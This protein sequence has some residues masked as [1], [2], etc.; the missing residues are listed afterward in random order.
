MKKFFCIILSILM[1]SMQCSCNKNMLNQSE[2]LK[3]FDINKAIRVVN[4]YMN[5]YMKNDI[6][7]ENGLYSKQFKKGNEDNKEQALFVNGYKFDEISQS[8]DMAVV[9]VKISKTSRQKP[10]VS[11]ESRTFKVIKEKGKYKIKSIDLKNDKEIFLG[12]DVSQIRIRFKDNVKTNLVTSFD[13]MPKYYYVYKDKAGNNKIP[14]SLGTYGILG[15]DYEGTS[16]IVTTKG[17][18][19]YI[20]LVDLDEAMMTEGDAQNSGQSSNGE[21]NIAPEKPIGKNITPLDLIIGATLS[22]IMFSEDGGFVAI[23]YSK[24]NTGF[25]IRVYRCRDGKIVP[26]NFQSKYPEEKVDVNIINFV[27]KGLV[28]KVT[29]KDKYKNDPKVKKLIGTYQMDVEKFKS[30]KVDENKAIIVY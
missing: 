24:P 15:I 21:V 10:Y 8:G 29:P 2:V 9:Q 30:K 5:A 26:F 11:L 14:V 4:I 3:K 20:E 25:T 28:Y 13:S 19:P 6:K 7:T 1:M 17:S 12:E 22:N 18:N 23:Q 27:K 16:V